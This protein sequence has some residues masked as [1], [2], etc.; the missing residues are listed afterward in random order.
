MDDLTRHCPFEEICKA[1]ENGRLTIMPQFVCRS[2]LCP[3]KMDVLACHSSNV[4]MCKVPN[5]DDLIRCSLFAE[6]C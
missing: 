5:K 1:P 6:I 2:T 3:P 4:E